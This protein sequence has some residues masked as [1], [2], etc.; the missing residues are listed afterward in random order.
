M[1]RLRQTTSWPRPHAAG[2]IIAKA[3]S[4]VDEVVA[5]VASTVDKVAAE[6][7]FKAKKVTVEAVSTALTEVLLIATRIAFSIMTS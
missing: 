7:A 2:E 6:G 1:P 3:A 5:E 4:T